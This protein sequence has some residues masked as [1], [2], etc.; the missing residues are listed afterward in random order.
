MSRSLLVLLSSC[1]LVALLLV[2]GSAVAQ[3]FT[4]ADLVGDYGF[5]AQKSGG[6]TVGRINHGFA[7]LIGRFTVDGMGNVSGLRSFSR[8]TL[9]P[10]GFVVEVFEQSFIGTYSVETDGTGL[11][12][13]EPT[14]NPPWV[15]NNANRH[16][17]LDGPETHRFVLT[18]GGRRLALTLDLPG[19]GFRI[20]DGADLGR[21]DVQ[22]GGR[23]ERQSPSNDLADLR[24]IVARQSAQL[25]ELLRLVNTPQ[26]QRETSTPEVV[27]ACGT[28]YQW[29][30]EGTDGPRRGR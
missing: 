9:A 11:M 10:T 23:A 30:G 12:T 5:E 27:E 19:Q 1:A 2:P 7:R 4:E 29:N 24:D 8:Q 20:A 13:I 21:A 16:T 14:P 26:G 15:G 22:L 6:D 18:A 3:G 25:C 28:G 17:V